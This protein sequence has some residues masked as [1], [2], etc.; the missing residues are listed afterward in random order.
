MR[1]LII[2]TIYYEQLMHIIHNQA[3]DN[4]KIILILEA[5]NQIAF[6]MVSV[7]IIP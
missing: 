5:Y 1:W 3:Y 7:K 6:E 2:L 4:T